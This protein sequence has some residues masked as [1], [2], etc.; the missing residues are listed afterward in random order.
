V[1]TLDKF[2]DRK[3]ESVSTPKDS[4]L[5][6]TKEGTSVTITHVNKITPNDTTEA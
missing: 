4:G 3:I 1:I 2:L 6:S 5:S